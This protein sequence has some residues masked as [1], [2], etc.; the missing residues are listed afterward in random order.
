M[1]QKNHQRRDHQRQQIHRA[2]REPSWTEH[3][4]PNGRQDQRWRQA[5]NVGD[6]TGEQLGR[7]D[8][9]VTSSRLSRCARHSDDFESDRKT[10][11]SSIFR[12]GSR[13]R[14]RPRRVLR[15]AELTVSEQENLAYQGR[16]SPIASGPELSCS[17][18]L[19]RRHVLGTWTLW[20]SA[21]R[22]RDLLAFVQLVKT[23]ALD[24]R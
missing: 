17:L 7:K 10:P 24:A 14:L 16:E 15:H 18:E 12:D 23:G 21:F 11:L 22:K 8:R 1:Q 3:C 9:V 4:Q 20:T 13:R 19:N 6:E 2:D 5:N